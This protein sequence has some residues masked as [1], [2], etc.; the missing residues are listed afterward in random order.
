MFV[1]FVIFGIAFQA[2]PNITNITNPGTGSAREVCGWL[3][4]LRDLVDVIFVVFVMFKNVLQ[5]TT[6]ITFSASIT[7]FTNP[8]AGSAR[9]VSGWREALLEFVSVMRYV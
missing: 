4:A 3:E 5:P 6:H 7:Q 9:E 8:G 1:M 2:I